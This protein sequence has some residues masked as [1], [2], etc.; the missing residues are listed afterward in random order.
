M[1]V[2]FATSPRFYPTLLAL[3]RE[4]AALCAFLNEPLLRVPSDPLRERS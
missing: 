4:V 3:F 2:A 1:N